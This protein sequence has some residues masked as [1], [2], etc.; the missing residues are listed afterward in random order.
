MA[1]ANS[2]D[3][4]FL[5]YRHY[6]RG[7]YGTALY[8]IPVDL[9]FGC[10]HRQA[11]G[12]GG[13]A[14]CGPASAR[15][16]HLCSTMELAAQVAAGLRVARE[17]SGVERYIAYFQAGTA[18]YAPPAVFRERV[19]AVLAAATF[20]VLVFATRPDCLPDAI[21]DYL[22]ELGREHEVWVELGVQTSH[23]ATLERVH[24]GH[25]FACSLR[26]ARELHSRGLAAAAHV[27]LGLP[28]EGPAEFALTAQ[29]LRV[30]PF[31][32][33][34]IH[35][36]HIVRGT[37]FEQLWR[38]GGIEAM[39]EHAYGEV[40]MTF[41]RHIP[42][43]WPVLRLSADT[44]TEQL[45]AP[46]WWM[47]KSEFRHYIATQMQQRG[48]TQGDLVPTAA[49]APASDD[50]PAT[51]TR[52]VL[53]ADLPWERRRAS[54][55]LNGL[56]EAVTVTLAE[57]A[58]G[59]LV[60]ALEFGQGPLA[61]DGLDVLPGRLASRVLIHGLTSDPEAL[62]RMRLQYPDYA[63]VLGALEMRG[64]CRRTWG[65]VAV[66][67]GDP[68]QTIVRITGRV[69]VV[70]LEP[71]RPEVCPWVFTLDFLRRVVRLMPPGAVL[72]SAC[73]SPALRGALLRLGLA[74]G[75]APDPLLPHGGTVAAWTPASVRLPLPERDRRIALECTSGIPYRDRAL[76]WTR[77]RILRHHE[78]L[79]ERMHS[80]GMP[81]RL[82]EG[83][84]ALAPAAGDA[85]A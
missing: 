79:S 24:R 30:A 4:P 51:Q 64:R 41:L 16:A 71:D 77:K 54:S 39:D 85:S 3:Q 32:G 42:A 50:P 13:C 31:S 53:P 10:P 67:W 33:I 21:L 19:Q 5:D 17:R 11:D 80:R 12:S 78:E 47:S 65:R 22:S 66:H 57:P 44:A 35:N 36:L 43:T 82:P 62:A 38:G 61:L 56:L 15:A 20:P 74:V 27:I 23:D 14:F 48:W 18:T 40:L 59:A 37:E 28:G 83:A 75:Y 70:L 58:R 1:P 84:A 63:G 25:D 60:L 7:R 8:R 76:N 49:G 29:R 68:R 72:L 46:R 73:S 52:R 2:S 55:A 26:A 69:D 9:G 81:A 34:K 45:L 6:L